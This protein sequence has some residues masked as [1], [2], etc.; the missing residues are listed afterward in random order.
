MVDPLKL[1]NV[2][3]DEY[4]NMR[5]DETG[6]PKLD[7][8]KRL[9]AFGESLPQNQLPN[10]TKIFSLRPY[11]AGLLFA[12]IAGLGDKSIR[13]LVETFLNSQL[14]EGG[15]PKLQS[16]ESL[17]SALLDFLD[18][19][20]ESCFTDVEKGYRPEMEIILSGYSSDSR[21]PEIF[22]L[23]LGPKKEMEPQILEGNY[24][25]VFGGQYDV[26]QRVV[27]GID[28]QGFCNIQAKHEI[29][30]NQYHESVQNWL[31]ENGVTLEVPVPDFNLSSG[32]IFAD[33]FGG[34]RGIFSDN[35]SLSEQAGI[36]FVEFLIATMINAQDFSDR[37]PTV[38]GQ[39]HVAI[40]TPSR[41]FKWISKEEF[42]FQNHSVPRYE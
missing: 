42:K 34:V 5:M 7:H 32:K 2:F 17:G 1:W 36:N 8:A 20:F 15:A 25:I 27:K 13:S 37:I 38:G 40:I 18:S 41:G 24:D 3:F 31:L 23:I 28:V 14:E 22:K 16:L 10:V 4:G 11:H 29:L 12:G 19:E 35:G 21:S 30:L 33:D 26:I 6:K 39:I 9:F